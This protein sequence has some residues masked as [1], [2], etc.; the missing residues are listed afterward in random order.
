MNDAM[1]SYFQ[2]T[3][4]GIEARLREDPSS[5]SPRKAYTLGMARL[6]TRLYD[7]GGRVA[8]C[9]V[10]APFDLLNAMGLTSC[11][12]EFVGASL[13]ASG[14]VHSFLD[15]AERA[16]FASDMCAY[17]RSV[18]GAALEGLLPVPLFLVATTCPCTAGLTTMENLARLFGRDLFVL[19]VPQDP[20]PSNVA[21]YVDQLED[22]VAFVEDHTEERL[23]PERLRAS[24][25]LTNEARSVL[26]DVYRLAARVP[27][28]ASTRDLRDLGVA[29][30]L[31]MGTRA[32]V[33]VA[34]AI[35]DVFEERIASGA[36]GVAS[37]RIRLMWIQNRLQFRNP[38]QSI[39]EQ[40]FHASIVVDEL[41]TINWD[42]VDPDD[43]FASIARRTIAIPLNGPIERRVRHLVDLARAYRVDGAIHPCHW[44]CRQGTGSRGMIQQGLESANVPV[45]N[46]E[47]DCV[48]TRAFS[49]GQV[50]TR[51]MAFCEMLASRP[52][53]WS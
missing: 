4:D 29:L 21:Y 35:R 32:A 5:M 42:P 9:G 41:N 51:L 33:D 25:A 23:D 47:T 31:L 19:H 7:P 13:A 6:G 15:T 52:S 16:G 22:M 37:E 53:P 30:P 12:V 46:L 14:T 10:A 43:P 18:M 24:L 39:L 36:P 28:P 34:T 45:L 38:V 26:V 40:E 2:A 20:S 27:S 48:D 3:V 44:G 1:M 11:F 49:E 50:R 8:W 17:H